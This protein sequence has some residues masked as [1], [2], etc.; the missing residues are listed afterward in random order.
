M[1]GARMG[2]GREAE[3]FAWGDDAVIKLYRAWF[4]GHV[5]ESQALLA[6]AGHAVAP[7]LRDVVERDGR[8]GLV[9]ERLDGPDLLGLVNRRPWLVLGVGRALAQSHLAVHALRAP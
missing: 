9:L 2:A 7:L 8:T 3:V 6:L 5:V 4:T 1:I